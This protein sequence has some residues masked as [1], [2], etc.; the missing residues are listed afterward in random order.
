MKLNLGCGNNKA[1]DYI[2]V[3]YS[4]SCK[5]DQVVDLE[6][7]PW[8]WPD[9]SVDEVVLFHCLEHLGRDPRVFLAIFQELY[10]VCRKDALIRIAVPHPRHDNFIGDPTHVMPVSPQMLA[11]F[12]R[13]ENDQ[14]QKDGVANTPLAHQLGVDF[15]IVSSVLELEEPYRTQFRQ[16][17]LSEKDLQRNLREKNNV[18]SEYKIEL[19]ARKDGPQPGLAQ[20]G[21]ATAFLHEP[22]WTGTEWRAV[23]GCYLAAFAPGEPVA[24]VLPLAP[25]DSL[26]EAEARVLEAVLASGRE[27]FPD[28]ILLA[29]TDSLVETLRR[30]PSIQWVPGPDGGELTGALGERF[31]RARQAVSAG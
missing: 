4:A 16:G 5:P 29:P 3:D 7:T 1:K 22:D 20:A 26:P 11:L 9:D 24:L 2:N 17:K 10:R 25:G 23:L 19:R 14:W 18:A 12:N 31:A 13:K 15:E 27:T 8:P 28:V 6:R 30:F 21:P